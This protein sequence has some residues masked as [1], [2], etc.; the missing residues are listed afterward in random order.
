[1]VGKRLEHH[2]DHVKKQKTK[3]LRRRSEL[4]T[5]GREEA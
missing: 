5:R 2:C 3:M 4:K 1:V